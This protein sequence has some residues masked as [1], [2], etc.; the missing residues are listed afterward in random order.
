LI[1]KGIIAQCRTRPP[2][3]AFVTTEAGVAK[4]PKKKEEHSH[5]PPGGMGGVDMM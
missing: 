1:E 5:M 3:L 4:A 2:S